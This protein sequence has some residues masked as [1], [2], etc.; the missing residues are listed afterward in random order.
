MIPLAQPPRKEDRVFDDWMYRLWKRISTAGGFGWD[1]VDTTGSNLTDLETRNHEDLQN[2]NT[3]S[4]THLTATDHTDLTDLGDTTLHFHS[5]DRDRANHTGEQAIS[6]VTG[7]QDALDEKLDIADLPANIM[8]YPT[9]TASDIGGY[10]KIVTDV[11]DPDFDNPAVDVST[12]NIST[13]SVLIASLATTAGIIIGNPGVVNLATVGNIRK[14]SGGANA[15]A[16]FYFQV[17]HRTTGGVESLIATSGTTSTITS[18]TYSTFYAAALL[19]NGAFLA[20]DRIVLKFYGNY[21]GSGS[22]PTYQFQ[23]GGTSPVRTSLPI[24]LIAIPSEDHNVLS[25]LQGGTTNQYYHLTQA[26][27][28]IVPT[29]FATGDLILGNGTNTSTRLSIGASG[30]VLQ[31]N[32]ST[33]TW[34]PAG[35]AST[36]PG[37]YVNIQPLETYT[38]YANYQAIVQGTYTVLGTLNV[39]G[40]LRINNG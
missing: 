23:F 27:S 4:Y 38:I 28:G 11:D 10:Y 37:I 3:A 31:S 34:Q 2:I 21:V 12:G 5:A 20:T 40:D 17:Y 33:A 14:V 6:T 35:A 1:L 18:A 30:Y 39:L 9:T 15:Y 8:L 16:N 22:S 32:G 24:P 36:F 29:A 19:N 7:L 25:G 26:Q 13:S